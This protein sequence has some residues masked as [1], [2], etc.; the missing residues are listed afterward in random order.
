M[1]HGVFS[2]TFMGE[3]GSEKGQSYRFGTSNVDYGDETEAIQALGVV[4]AASQVD[5]A[6]CLVADE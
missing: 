4:G 2:V 6:V 5:A 1:G 3:Q